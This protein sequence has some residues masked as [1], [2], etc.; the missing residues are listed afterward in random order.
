MV[1]LKKETITLWLLAVYSLELKQLSG[2]KEISPV[3]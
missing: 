2:V 1:F 3:G